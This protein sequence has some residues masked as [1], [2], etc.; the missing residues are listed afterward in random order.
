M[1][2]E[3]F[4][5][6]IRTW[7]IMSMRQ[8]PVI[9]ALCILPTSTLQAGTSA[10]WGVK[11]ELWNPLGRLPDFSYAGYHAGEKA[12]P[13]IS[14]IAN[15]KTFGCLGDGK[16][17]D[18]PCLQNAI[19]ATDLG[20]L[21][22][23]KGRYLL[24]RQIQIR[25]SGLVLRG[26][27]SGPD[28]TVLIWSKGLQ[29]LTGSIYPWNWGASGLLRYS[30]PKTIPQP[31]SK[32][33]AKILSKVA[34]HPPTGDLAL[35]SNFATL[36]APAKRGDTQLQLSKTTGLLSGQFIV[37]TLTDP[38]DRSLN[39]CLHNNQD[40]NDYN[41]DMPFRWVVQIKKVNGNSI[42]LVQPLRFD[43]RSVWLPTINLYHPIEESGLENM[44]ME[45]PDQV[46]AG[47]QLE[48]G[49]N[50]FSF[51]GALNCWAK[52]ITIQNCDNGPS[53]EELTKNCTVLELT[54]LP[55]S[56]LTLN[57]RISGH[58]GFSFN[59]NSHDNLLSGFDFQ[60]TFIHGV[61]V[62]YNASGNVIKSGKGNDLNL[63]HHSRSPI[64]NLYS[65][66]DL[67]LGAYPFIPVAGAGGDPLRTGARGT[68]WN[69][70]SRSGVVAPPPFAYLQFNMIG[71]NQDKRTENREWLEQVGEIIPADLFTSQVERRL[72]VTQI[73]LPKIQRKK[74]SRQ[75]I[76][77]FGLGF[78]I[79]GKKPRQ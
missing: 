54:Q 26:E 41:Q 10:L 29:E 24:T 18:S 19:D 31:N 64:E 20:A 28:G 60:A 53:L 51:E 1:D 37:L 77:E 61:S 75:F 36:T 42:I 48:P 32:T 4:T 58:H 57:G 17:D 72:S 47:H 65:D 9:V 44:R 11:G 71:T 46:Y 14:V 27:G 2:Q 39:A 7:Q 45:F 79:N 74:V 56:T 35:G 13:T 68:V 55:R 12:I 78:S 6:R 5:N 62:G 63:D 67:G 49:Y 21:F 38:I 23:P 69:I 25:K 73:S 3:R 43:I 33:T 15:V 76:P 16:T 22:I 50:A 70:R 66:I 30:P 34:D 59:S 52:N 8:L 40:S